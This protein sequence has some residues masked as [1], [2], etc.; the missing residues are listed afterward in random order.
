MQKITLED[1]HKILEKKG[2]KI[3]I[4]RE[5]KIFSAIKSAFDNFNDVL[6]N[7]AY[8]VQ[9][10]DINFVQNDISWR[11]TYSIVVNENYCIS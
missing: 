1:I 10:A 2:I 7:K 5:Q 11:F 9:L 3:T 6:S 8:D 4:E